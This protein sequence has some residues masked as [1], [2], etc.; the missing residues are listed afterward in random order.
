MSSSD[1]EI[2]YSSELPG[3]NLK[4]Q[5]KGE[6]KENKAEIIPSETVLKLRIEKK[7]RGGKTVT[8]I[9]ELPNNPKYFKRLLKELKN[10]CGTGGAQKP[11]QL[12]I[13]GDLR[14]KIRLFLIAKGFTVKG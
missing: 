3:L 14:E 7:G 12:E 10:Q 4:K 11:S 5:R 13:Q 2:V 9:D 1:D 8:V 6:K